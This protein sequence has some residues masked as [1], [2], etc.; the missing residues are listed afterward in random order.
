ME[1]EAERLRSPDYRA[2]EIA[3]AARRGE[4]VTDRE[5]LELIPKLREGARG[6]RRGAEEMRR[7]AERMRR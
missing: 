4:T 6:L 1:A 5:L 3:K 7:E 2:A